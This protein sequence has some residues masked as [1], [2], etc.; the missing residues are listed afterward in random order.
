M[1]NARQS[2]E[3]EAGAAEVMIGPETFL[4]K[5]LM[6]SVG[7]LPAQIYGTSLGSAEMEPLK[8]LM[9]AVLVDAIRCYR[10]GLEAIALHEQR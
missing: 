7:M 5:S 4:D 10:R 2:M 6:G 9:R 3:A 1:Y 8:H